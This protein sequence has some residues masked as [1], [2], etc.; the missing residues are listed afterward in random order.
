MKLTPLH[1]SRSGRL[2]GLIGL[3]CGALSL[4]SL[5]A[6]W[7][8]PNGRAPGWMSPGNALCL[9]LS[10]ASL[11]GLAFGHGAR[12]ARATRALS[13]AC[14]LI[15]GAALVNHVARAGIGPLDSLRMMP[16]SA[17]AFL[18]LGAA[19]FLLPSRRTT[20]SYASQGLALAVIALGVFAIIGRLYGTPPLFVLS[21]LGRISVSAAMGLILAAVGVF[22]ARRELGVPA[23]FTSAGP[24]G[25]LA[26]RLLLPVLLAPIAIGWLVLE[27]MR[28][29]LHPTSTAIALLVTALAIVQLS[30]ELIFTD[31]LEHLNRRYA[32]LLG[33][34]R[35]AREALE[36]AEERLRLAL[37]C[38]A[39]G[40]WHYDPRTDRV[41][42]S[43]RCQE[44]FGLSPDQAG[45][46]GQ[47]IE[48][49]LGRV[50][51]EDRL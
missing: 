41:R 46:A 40:A 35:R 39:I 51:P 34:S 25:L 18:L 1:A 44:M 48:L 15:S 28:R 32:L 9:L 8:S 36:Q 11:L 7:S 19:L 21:S 42:A 3:V 49:Y 47:S 2:T 16:N 30:V 5:N 33:D 10:S 29:G 43:P 24:G 26:R 17:L 31:Q 20:S 38:G 4:A 14:A 12:I 13:G 27:G 23:L 37:Q 45:N 50:H 22:A 6:V